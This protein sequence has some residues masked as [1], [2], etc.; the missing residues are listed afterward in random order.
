MGPFFCKN[1]KYVWLRRK[2][3]LLFSQLLLL[4]FKQLSTHLIGGYVLIS[5]QFQKIKFFSFLFIYLLIPFNP[6]LSK[7][8][9]D[10]LEVDM[11]LLRCYR[12]KKYCKEALFEI[13]H[14]QKKAA[15]NKKFSCQTRLLGLEANLILA[16]NSNFKLKEAKIILDAIK[17]YC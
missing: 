11:L 16:M 9:K 13:N 8:S 4:I 6:L 3:L 2:I 17:K 15:I 5:Y 7:E 10:F 12:D 14:Y 1:L